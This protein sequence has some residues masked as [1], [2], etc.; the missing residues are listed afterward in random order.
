LVETI[1]SVKGQNLSKEVL[2]EFLIDKRNQFLEIANDCGSTKRTRQLAMDIT[3]FICFMCGE[4]DN[5]A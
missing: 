5:H 2:K 3:E 1:V 4:Y